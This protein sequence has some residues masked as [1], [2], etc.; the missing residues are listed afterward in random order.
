MADEVIIIL[1][2]V[3]GSKKDQICGFMED[4]RLKIKIA[5][6]AVDGK[7]NQRLL[8]YLSEL[9]GIKKSCISIQSGEFSRNKKLLVTGVDKKHLQKSLIRI[10]N[11]DP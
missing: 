10:M 3:P 6:R 7:A 8:D 1:H 9:F 5:A 2:V 4:G 11:Q